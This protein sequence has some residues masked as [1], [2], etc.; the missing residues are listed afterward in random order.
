MMIVY[1]NVSSA[2]RLAN[3][4]DGLEKVKTI[5]AVI[6]ELEDVRPVSFILPC[7]SIYSDWSGDIPQADSRKTT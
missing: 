6:S 1:F 4:T 2:R 3:D 7:R 5:K